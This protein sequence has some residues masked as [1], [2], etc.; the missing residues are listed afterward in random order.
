[1]VIIATANALPP[2]RRQGICCTNA[3]LLSISSQLPLSF[4]GVLDVR[5]S[6]IRPRESPTRHGSHT[7]SAC[8]R[9]RGSIKVNF[10]ITTDNALV[11][12]RCQNITCDDLYLHTLSTP[13]CVCA[14]PGIPPRPLDGSAR[15]LVGIFPR[16]QRLIYI[17]NSVS[18]YVCLC[19]CLSVYESVCLDT[20]PRL[21]GG[22][23]SNLVERCV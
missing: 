16:P 21:L 3:D 7:R 12:S 4:E 9:R 13:V 10:T 11:W 20:P 17:I 22:F 2:K 8:Y 1:M 19:V 6:E 14:C 15:Y 18:T 5:Y 23:T